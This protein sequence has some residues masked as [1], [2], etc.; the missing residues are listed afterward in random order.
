M[1]NFYKV[2]C[3]VP[4]PGTTHTTPQYS[5]AL[6]YARTATHEIKG[7]GCQ[8]S[9]ERHCQPIGSISLSVP[10]GKEKLDFRNAKKNQ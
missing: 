7:K 1:C 9:G 10:V 3:C 5:R 2:F 4:P 6:T 8:S